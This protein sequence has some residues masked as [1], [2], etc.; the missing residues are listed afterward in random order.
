MPRALSRL[1]LNRGG[2]RDLGAQC[3]AGLR[4]LARWP[5]L[6][7]APAG[8]IGAGER[9]RKP[10]RRGW[11]EHLDAALADELPLLKRDGGFVRSG[12]DAELG[13]DAGAGD[14]IAARDRRRW[15]AT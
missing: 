11:L 6:A 13:R 9:D 5:V 15:S 3:A 7:S 2:P 1:A 14:R 4:R 8:G 10:C 12:Y